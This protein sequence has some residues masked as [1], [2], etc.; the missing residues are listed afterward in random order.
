[1]PAQRPGPQVLGVRCPSGH[2]NPP[3]RAACRTCGV[4]VPDAE[5]TLL[6]RP[7]LGRLRTSEGATALLDRTV[8]VGRAP[9]AGRFATDEAPHL[10]RVPSP[11][12]D[13]SRTHVEVRVE[14][15]D[16]LAVDVS[17]NGTRLVRPGQDPQ[18]LH[19]GE[20]VLV[21]PGS[22]LDLGDGVTLVYEVDAT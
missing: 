16:V 9:T 6:P 8:L 7:A 15:W 19:K 14:D 10:L 4:A 20:P 3:H 12:Q 21:L 5:P 13:I 1:M 11:Q 22:L 18:M 17:S 2:A